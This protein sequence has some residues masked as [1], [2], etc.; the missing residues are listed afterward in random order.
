M[1]FIL[2]FSKN[3]YTQPEYNNSYELS[4]SNLTLLD[5][6]FIYTKKLN[7]SRYLEVSNSFVMHKTIESDAGSMFY[8]NQ[9]PYKLYD[10]YRLRVGI[11]YFK[12]NFNYICPMLIFNYGNYR[13]RMIIHYIDEPGSDAYDQDY[14]LTRNKFEVGYILKFGKVALDGKNFL[15][16][17]YCGFGFKVKFLNSIVYKKWLHHQLYYVGEPIY[18]NEIKYM[19]TFH[20]G[21]LFGFKR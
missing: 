18:M 15:W 11:R 21:M 1:A 19:P 2:M 3:T 12:D 13:N 17:F 20:I 4:L 7:K 5:L 14:L 10:L 8:N 9:D 6:T 16:D